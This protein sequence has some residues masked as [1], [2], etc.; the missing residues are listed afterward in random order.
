MFHTKDDQTRTYIW[1]DIQDSKIMIEGQWASSQS[2]NTCPQPP[3]SAFQALLCTTQMNPK[4]VGRP[5]SKDI[6][7]EEGLCIQ[8]ITVIINDTRFHTVEDVYCACLG[9]VPQSGNDLGH[10]SAKRSWGT[11]HPSR[12]LCVTLLL[13]LPQLQGLPSDKNLGRWSLDVYDHFI[14]STVKSSC[15][16]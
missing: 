6:M 7:T 3:P 11:G 5:W 4:T 10:D 8:I 13:P 12:W 16:D 1:R 14:S 9:Q 2:L 15:F